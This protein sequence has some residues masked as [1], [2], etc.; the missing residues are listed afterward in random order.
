[1][2]LCEIS[3]CYLFIFLNY[4]TQSFTWRLCFHVVP[5]S[6]WKWFEFIIFLRVCMLAESHKLW[7]IWALINQVL[8]RC[9]LSFGFWLN[10]S[11]RVKQVDIS[12][13]TDINQSISVNQFYPIEALIFIREF[14]CFPIIHHNSIFSTHMRKVCYSNNWKARHF[15]RSVLKLLMVVWQLKS[16]FDLRI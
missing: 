2:N 6:K 7:K 15:C 5:N 13:S 12:E 10:N 14:C 3:F 1:M 4:E 9:F 8:P 11:N 16:S